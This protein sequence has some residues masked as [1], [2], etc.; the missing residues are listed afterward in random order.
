MKWLCNYQ[1]YI[2]VSKG[3]DEIVRD[4]PFFDDFVWVR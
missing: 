4:K 3:F 1:L 2:S